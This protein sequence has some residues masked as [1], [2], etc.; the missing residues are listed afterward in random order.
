M[1][2]NTTSINKPAQNHN[3]DK[4]QAPKTPLKII[5]INIMEAGRRKVT[6][7]RSGQIN[8]NPMSF[9]FKN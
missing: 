7:Y 3:R 2:I 5:T 4:N 9:S 8:T 6:N 1:I